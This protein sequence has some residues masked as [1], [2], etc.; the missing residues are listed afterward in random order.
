MNANL[1]ATERDFIDQFGM[2]A[3]YNSWDKEGWIATMLSD[4]RQDSEE[5]AAAAGIREAEARE[6]SP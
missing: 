1:R 5:G 2:T 6:D 4:S 3:Q